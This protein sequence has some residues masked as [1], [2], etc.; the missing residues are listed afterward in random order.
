MVD[1]WLLRRC[2]GK[3]R[4]KERRSGRRDERDLN[5][6]SWGVIVHMWRR[7]AG[8]V[9][10]VGSVARREIVARLLSAFAVA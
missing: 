5:A 3:G 1:L 2:W 10:N 8:R 9:E 6:W 7:R 4:G